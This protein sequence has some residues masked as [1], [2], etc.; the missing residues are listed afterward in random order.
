[1]KTLK[2]NWWKLIIITLVTLIVR[3]LLLELLPLRTSTTFEFELSVLSQNIGMI[4]TAAIVIALS[5]LVIASVLIIVQEGLPG[6]KLARMILCSLPYSLIWLMAVLESVASLGRPLLPE[7]L[8]AVTDIIPILVMGGMIGSWITNDNPQREEI[9]HRPKAVSIL[10][11]AF[12]Y[13]VG[14]YLMYTLIHINSGYFSQEVATFLWTLALGLAIG[15]AY[16]MLRVGAKG[17]SPLSRGLWFGR[18]AFGLY[19]T[20]NNAFMP[21]VFDMSFILFEPTIMNYVYR[22][23]VDIIFVSLGV[24]IVE[25]SHS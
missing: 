8:I 2:Q 13:F 17:N 15:S 21:I 16:F 19:W 23:V 9:A 22:A 11:I 7:L 5:Y 25:K 12:T 1:M 6:S 24:W 20:L 18:V 4:P 14:R 10:I 3:V